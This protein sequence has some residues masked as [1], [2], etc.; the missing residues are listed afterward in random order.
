MQIE[1][2][3]RAETEADYFA[4][5]LGFL[6]HKHPSHLHQK[7]LKWGT[8][9][10]FYSEVSDERTTA[11]LTVDIDSIAL[12]RGRNDQSS[13]LLGQ[14]VN[15]RPYAANSFLTVALSRLLGQ[16]I[17]GKS[18]EKQELADRALPFEVRIVPIRIVGGREIAKEFLEPLGY[19]I[20]I[21]D[22]GETP[23][24]SYGLFDL[25]LKAEIKLSDLLSQ[26]YVLISVLDN[27]KH[28]WV[29][30]D[31]VDKLVDKGKG[32]LETHPAKELIT[33]RALKHR[34]SLA[35]LALD[36]LSEGREDEVEGEEPDTPKP[37]LDREEV[38]ER[39][40]R[41]HDL[42][43]DRV[44]EVLGENKVSSVLDLGCGEGKLL[45]RLVK[46]RGLSKIVGVDASVRTLER[47]HKRLHLD[48]AGDAMRDRLILQ[49]GSLTYCDRRWR[50]FEAATLVE[51]IEH[52]DLPRLPSLELSLF[53]E[54]RPRLVVVTTPNVEYNQLF[55]K[56]AEGDLR[57]SD[58]RFEWTRDEFQ[59][60]ANRVCETYDYRVEISPLGPED[61]NYGAPS[62]MAVFKIGFDASESESGQPG[63]GEK[64]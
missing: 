46:E 64:L 43:L 52:I 25:R 55:E 13:G 50:D 20:D 44:A 39:P 4:S 14:Y 9:S 60:W 45:A 47:A 7:N 42:R 51:V 54:A 58:H 8:G 18:K 12:V 30:E 38:L 26:L 19:E 23:E 21:K 41:L 49:M 31:E 5:D 36:R 29:A 2:T 37:R 15:D 16:S 3:L 28:F 32:W 53:G 11:V 6:L 63:E 59:Q 10:I 34:R 61:D 27:Q 24:Q 22:I 17:S 33:R 1:L 57:H 62:Q 48:T 40:I 35:H 56:M